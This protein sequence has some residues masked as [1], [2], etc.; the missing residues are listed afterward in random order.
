MG[1][2]GIS[3]SLWRFGPFTMD[4][5]SHELRREGVPIKLQDQPARILMF[6]LERP[7]E[8]ISRDELQRSL[9]SSETFVDFDHSLNTA[10]MKLREALGDAADNPKYIETIPKRGYR[11][12]APVEPVGNR[13]GTRC[14]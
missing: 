5:H 13:V 14:P 6:L 4:G 2:P 9:W 10:V 12:I 11:F 7:G 3:G 1:A 8:M